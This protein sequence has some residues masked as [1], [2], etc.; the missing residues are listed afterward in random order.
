LRQILWL[1]CQNHSLLEAFLKA[2]KL[3]S[4]ALSF[5]NLTVSVGHTAVDALVLHGALEEAFASAEK[6]S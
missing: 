6:S 4:V 5:V 1:T 3:A 2:T